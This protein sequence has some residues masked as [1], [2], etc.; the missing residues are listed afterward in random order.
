MTNLAQ[1]ESCS[2]PCKFE[3]IA[4]SNTDCFEQQPTLE[5]VKK[6]RKIHQTNGYKDI[7]K[8]N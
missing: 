3:S 7:L 5:K 6:E 2:H 1:T 4:P 8:Y